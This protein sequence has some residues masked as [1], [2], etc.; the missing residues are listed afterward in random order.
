MGGVSPLFPCPGPDPAEPIVLRDG[1]RV[2]QA[3]IRERP[4]WVYGAQLLKGAAEGDETSMSGPR[5]V[6]RLWDIRG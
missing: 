4:V 2:K 1:V 3:F 5:S 6:S